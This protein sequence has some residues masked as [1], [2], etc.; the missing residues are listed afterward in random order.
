MADHEA[1]GY[2]L[3]D[4]LQFTEPEQYKALFEE[5]RLQIIDLLTQR[6]ATISELAETLGKPKGTVGHHIGVLED[7]G[8][9][10]VVRTKKVRAIEAKYYGRTARTYLLGDKTDPGFG[11]APDHFLTAAAA[12]FVDAPKDDPVGA[13]STLRYAR[14]PTE[15]ADEWAARLMDLIT[16]YTEEPRGGETTYGLLVAM[17]PTNRPH[18]PDEEDRG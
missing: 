2:D 13:L 7:A 1:P 10:R 6:A 11:L 18:L 17:Y 4:T 3:E 14:I 8:L 16:E 9:I 15:K 12:E 5:T